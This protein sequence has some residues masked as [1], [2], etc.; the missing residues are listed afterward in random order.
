MYQLAMLSG[1]RLAFVVVPIEGTVKRNVV[2]WDKAEGLVQELADQPGGFL[3][4]CPRGHVV[5]LRDEKALRQYGVHKK[6]RIINMS[7]LYDPESPM[8]RLM[9][10]QDDK[11]RTGAMLEMQE[12]VIQL[13]TAQ[14]GNRVLPEQNVRQPGD[15]KPGEALVIRLPGAKAPATEIDED[16]ASALTPPEPRVR[17]NSKRK[18]AA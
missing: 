2:K 1:A 15:R 17:S 13:A 12:M 7:E 3:V 11:E 14:T 6:A 8:G 5:R 10:A 16:E 9:T 18:R 4:Y